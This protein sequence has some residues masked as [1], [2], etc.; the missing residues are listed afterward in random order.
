[1]ECRHS[2]GRRGCLDLTSRL[3]LHVGRTDQACREADV[4]LG[5]G[6][7]TGLLSLAAFA[8]A[9]EDDRFSWT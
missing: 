4:A 5:L 8:D 3:E 7:H 6:Y 2:T 1:M 9:S